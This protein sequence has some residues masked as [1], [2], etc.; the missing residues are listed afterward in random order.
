MTD[1]TWIMGI[2]LATVASFINNIGVNLQKLYHTNGIKAYWLAG[3]LAIATGSVLDITA[4]SFAPQSVIAPLGSLTIVSNT[5]VA[6]HMHGEKL[7]RW[8]V[9][10]T[11]VVFLGCIVSVMSA[12]HDL[13]IL[14]EESLWEM[15][16]SQRFTVYIISILGTLMLCV[17]SDEESFIPAFA[18]ALFGSLSVT[19]AKVSNNVLI[20]HGA[21]TWIVIGILT[22]QVL[23]VVMQLLYLNLALSLA[24][25]LVVV[26]VFTS[27]WII[28]T[29]LAGGILYEEF[30]KFTVLQG[31]L[32]P[33]GVLLCCI[34]VFGLVR[35]RG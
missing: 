21:S 13:V 8:T 1:E 29:A 2:L 25:A 12:S 16:T 9:M 27:T 33:V 15:L 7:T 17:Q 23:C 3:M 31:V 28:T 11:L 5:L 6:P 34:G 10:F 24:D 18:S 26:P 22:A 20:L 4:L 19:T 14:D 30:Y 32:F 35:S